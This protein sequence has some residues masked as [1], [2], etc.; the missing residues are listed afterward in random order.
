MLFRSIVAIFTAAEPAS[1]FILRSNS[2]SPG[3]TIPEQYSYSGYGCTG[4]NSSPELSWSGAPADTKTFALTMFD[5]DARGGQGWWHWVV[6]NI[7]PDVTK[8]QAG[9]GGASN[10]VMP[11]G[12]VQ[13]RNDF[14]TIGYGGPCPP[15][16]ESAHHYRFTIY[17]LNEH[18]D[19]LSPVSSGPT[20]I[21]AMR[22]HILGKTVLMG[23]F[24]R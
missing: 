8:L 2:F 9:A 10:D 15:A 24:S 5:T 23:L 12:A 3:G 19:G 4:R 1:T 20:V 17:A 7:P 13:G 21:A 22:G 6:F 14:Q 16:G 11:R 18:L